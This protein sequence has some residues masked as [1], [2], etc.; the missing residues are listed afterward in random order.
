MSNDFAV[1]H[2]ADGYVKSYIKD[3]AS[4]LDYTWDW[5]DWLASVDDAIETATV[6]VPEGLTAVQAPV[7][8][9]S[10]VTQVVEG[11]DLESVYRMICRINTVGGLTDQRSIYL[12]VRDR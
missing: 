6:T 5:A 12:T 4:R 1:V 2:V 9:N 11:G 3:P 8:D 7:R 10:F